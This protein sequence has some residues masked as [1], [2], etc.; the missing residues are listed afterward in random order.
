MEKVYIYDIC[1]A[2]AE[3]KDKLKSHIHCVDCAI[4]FKSMSELNNHT[5]QSHTNE[6]MVDAQGNANKGKRKIIDNKFEID[7][8]RKD[9]A[10][11]RKEDICFDDRIDNQR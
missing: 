8:C 7:K 3:S 1:D 5:Q 10:E 4:Q 6:I 9:L 2:E 11:K